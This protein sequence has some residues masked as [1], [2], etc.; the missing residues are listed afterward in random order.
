MRSPWKTKDVT[1]S[2][3]GSWFSKRG[4]LHKNAYVIDY[5]VGPDQTDYAARYVI[6]KAMYADIQKMMSW[7]FLFLM[8][9]PVT[10]NLKL[11]SCVS[12]YKHV[13]Q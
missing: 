13:T 8:W 11:V 4:L 5:N 3:Y 2:G 1:I 6:F 9:W 12:N 7:D 10:V